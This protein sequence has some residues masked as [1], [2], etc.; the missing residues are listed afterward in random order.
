M[1]PKYIVRV[2]VV[3]SHLDPFCRPIS[4]VLWQRFL[5]LLSFFNSFSNRLSSSATSRSLFGPAGKPRNFPPSTQFLCRPTSWRLD[6]LLP[7]RAK[8]SGGRK[9]RARTN[10]REGGQLEAPGLPLQRGSIPL[11]RSTLPSP[12]N[13]TTRGDIH[14]E[15]PQHR[16]LVVCGG[17]DWF[18][19]T[20]GN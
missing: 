13:L 10:P 6:S 14:G 8:D 20:K 19:A 2:R 16:F 4:S 3:L 9:A 7:K 12:V 18:L 1:A 5:F 11:P 15:I 17:N